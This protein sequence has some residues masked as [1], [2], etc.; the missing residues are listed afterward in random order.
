MTQTLFS[1]NLTKTNYITN[2]DSITVIKPKL[3]LY[4]NSKLYIPFNS[5]VN[6]CDENESYNNLS[7]S[8]LMEV[9]F[10]NIIFN[11]L[12][13][14]S[15][16]LDYHF[17]DNLS[18]NSKIVFNNIKYYSFFPKDI[19]LEEKKNI[20]DI[21]IN[22]IKLY[23][24]EYPECDGLFLFHKIQ[25]YMIR[26]KKFNSTGSYSYYFDNPEILSFSYERHTKF[27][28]IKSKI[29]NVKI[30]VYYEFCDEFSIFDF[31]YPVERICI[32]NDIVIYKT[33]IT[34]GNFE[35]KRGICEDDDETLITLL[36]NLSKN[37]MIP[38]L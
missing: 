15:Y 10:S 22:N 28:N 8:I 21:Y 37:K 38:F 1:Q 20:L 36:I 12:E 2:N 31:C 24:E 32:I 4:F 25:D 7:V 6:Y 29:I 5:K 23:L 34:L 33:N 11:K 27:E 3:I 13:D 30:E 9:Y 35:K 26:T 16:V 14:N 19:S 18:N 17:N